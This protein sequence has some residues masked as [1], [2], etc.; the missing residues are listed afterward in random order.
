MTRKLRILHLEDNPV[1]SE[2]IQATLGGEEI[3]SEIV[4]VETREGLSLPLKRAGQT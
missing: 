1:D 2:L 4:R 3:E